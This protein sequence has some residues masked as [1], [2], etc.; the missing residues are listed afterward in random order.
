MPGSLRLTYYPGITQY[1]PPQTVHDAVVKFAALV[2]SKGAPSIT[3][4]APVEIPQQITMIASGGCE[5][6]LMNPLGF[7]FAHRQEAKV[8]P[9]AVVIRTTSAGTGPAY[10]S[11]VYVNVA[12]GITDVR[13]LRGRSMGF[14]SAVSTSNFLAPAAELRRRGVHPLTAMRLVQY[15]GHHDDV[16]QAVYEG[17][18]DAGAGHDGVI[19]DLAKTHPDAVQKLRRLFWSSPIPSDPI[20]VNMTEP[21][22]SQLRA[23]IIAAGTEQQ[24]KDAIATFWGTPNGLDNVKSDF[25]NGLGKY[26]DDLSL[27]MEDIL[28]A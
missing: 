2:T 10:L 13:G 8:V 20:A 1:Q 26:L 22:I 11:Q 25:Y 7:L 21:S 3:V 4:L 19:D 12:S 27:R 9:V 14:G 15:F 16:A 6:G 17:K 18:V 24:G 28:P 5:I 23:A